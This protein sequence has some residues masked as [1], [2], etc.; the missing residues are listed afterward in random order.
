MLVAGW[1]LVNLDCL[2]LNTKS[3]RIPGY[4]INF[5]SSWIKNCQSHLIQSLWFTRSKCCTC[6][7]HRTSSRCQLPTKPAM[8]CVILQSCLVANMPPMD[9][10]KSYFSNMYENHFLTNFSL[11]SVCLCLLPLRWRLRSCL[12]TA[13]LAGRMLDAQL[14]LLCSKRSS[15]SN[16]ASGYSSWIRYWKGCIHPICHLKKIQTEI[17][18]C[19]PLGP[20]QSSELPP[21][22][23]Q[24]ES[25]WY[26]G[27]G[28]NTSQKVCSPNLT[29]STF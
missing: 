10:N 8:M 24:W 28:F 20:I 1:Y 25:S 12:M 13:L 17:Q 14:P 5:T 29:S 16:W 4:F 27:G 23:L 3:I 9:D 21:I 15:T 7:I 2:R 22:W 18:A 19:F 26:V 11:K 6:G